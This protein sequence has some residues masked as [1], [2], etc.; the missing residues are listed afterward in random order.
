VSIFLRGHVRAD[1]TLELQIPTK[2]SDTDVEVTI[3]L[4]PVRADEAESKKIRSEQEFDGAPIL[5]RLSDLLK[6][7]EFGIGDG[8]AFGLQQ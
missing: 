7:N 6:F 8:H 4:R 3:T 2:L 5:S 1:G